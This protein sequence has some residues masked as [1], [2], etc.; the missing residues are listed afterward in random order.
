MCFLLKIVK[1][2]IECLLRA[3]CP[4]NSDKYTKLSV[5]EGVWEKGAFLGSHR[6]CSAPKHFLSNEDRKER[7]EGGPKHRGAL[8]FNNGWLLP[9][10]VFAS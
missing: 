7:K 8:T 9:F 5:G 1:A 10:Q 3:E 6:I 4:V 2:F